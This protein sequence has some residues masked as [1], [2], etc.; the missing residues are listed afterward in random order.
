[1]TPCT[2][3]N[4]LKSQHRVSLHCAGSCNGTVHLSEEVSSL[5]KMF[6]SDDYDDDGWYKQ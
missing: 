2:I 6:Y 3:I 1:M 4:N 5:R